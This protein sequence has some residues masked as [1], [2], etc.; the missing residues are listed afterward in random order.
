MIQSPN[1]NMLQEIIKK[2]YEFVKV[3]DFY[4]LDYPS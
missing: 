2:D 4:F 1:I 3:G